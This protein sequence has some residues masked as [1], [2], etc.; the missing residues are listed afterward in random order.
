MAGDVAPFGAG[1]FRVEVRGHFKE[2]VKMIPYRNLQ[3]TFF[4]GS[5]G[6]TLT[7]DVS[8]RK[9]GLTFANFY[10]GKHEIWVW[11]AKVPSFP[12]FAGPITQLSAN[13]TNGTISVNASDPLWYLSRRVLFSQVFYSGKPEA[14]MQDL[15]SKANTASPTGIVGHIDQNGTQ[16]IAAMFGQGEVNDFATYFGQLQTMGDGID[17]YIR[18]DGSGGSNDRWLHMWGGKKGSTP[19]NLPLG[20]NYPSEVLPAYSLQLIATGIANVVIVVGQG[21]VAS[22]GTAYNS[23]K[24][25]EYNYKYDL[26]TDSNQ[27]STSTLNQQAAQVLKQ[28]QSTQQVPSITIRSEYYNPFVDF[29]LGDKFHVRIDDDYV[30]IDQVIRCIGFQMTVDPNDDIVTNIYTNS[31]EAVT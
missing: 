22:F 16:N 15:L 3:M 17:Y 4:L 18:N 24:I 2:M 13:S 7:M 23:S 28:V 11:D 19:G 14:A 10:P 21:S 1:R 27:N 5:Q 8:F 12:I 29:D 26:A 9:L 31:T 25:T 20:L 6:A 30:Q